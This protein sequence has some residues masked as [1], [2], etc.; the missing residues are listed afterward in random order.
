LAGVAGM[1]WAEDVRRRRTRPE[2]GRA[3]EDFG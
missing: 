3:V 2:S 1:R